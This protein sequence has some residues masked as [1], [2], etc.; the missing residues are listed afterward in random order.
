MSDPIRLFTDGSCRGNPGPGG[1]GVLICVDGE[2]I[3]IVGGEKDTTNNRMEIM[4]AIQGLECLPDGSNVELT[5]D[6][7]YV[8]N[9]MTEWVKKWSSKNWMLSANQPVKN[10]DLWKRL[11]EAEQKHTVEWK[12]VKGHNGHYE[13]ERADALAN[14]GMYQVITGNT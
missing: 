8:V 5:T 6:S 12:W 2:E 13:N 7:K 10:V 9:G 4:A 11:V 14:R 1:W 3:E